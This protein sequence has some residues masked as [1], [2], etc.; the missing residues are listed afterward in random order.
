MAPLQS[1]GWLFGN[2]F[3][4]CPCHETENA[5]L[6]IW[7]SRCSTNIVR[8]SRSKIQS[9]VSFFFICFQGTSSSSTHFRQ[10][11][12][13]G[14]TASFL[15][16]E[17]LFSFALFEAAPFFAV[18]AGGSSKLDP[19]PGDNCHSFTAFRIRTRKRLSLSRYFYGLSSPCS[20]DVRGSFEVE[21]SLRDG[22]SSTR[23]ESIWILLHGQ[24]AREQRSVGNPRCSLHLGR[25]VRMSYLCPR[26]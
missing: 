5:P 25:W 6:F 16:T 10:Q 22:A 19:S 7:H 9:T 24:S 11:I 23:E 17:L 13:A 15:P 3:T 21:T 26:K 18:S 1:L 4:S 14:W 2:L 12:V 20:A 8:G